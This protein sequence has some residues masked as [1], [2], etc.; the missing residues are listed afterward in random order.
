MTVANDNGPPITITQDY[1]HQ[2]EFLFGDLLAPECQ[3]VLDQN[4]F[5][6]LKAY[7]V[8][9]RE[10]GDVNFQLERCVDYRDFTDSAGYTTSWDNDG[11]VWQDEFVDLMMVS[12]TQNLGFRGGSIFREGV[13]IDLADIDAEIAR[14]QAESVERTRR[15]AIASIRPANGDEQT[16]LSRG[17]REPGQP[18]GE[19]T[20]LKRDWI[21]TASRS[22]A[23]AQWIADQLNLPLGVVEQVIG[24]NGT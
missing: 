2:A 18:Y 15:R 5:E 16:F 6:V 12:L 3:I 1:T 13:L 4:Q 17:P 9:I 21:V 11:E 19:L 23:P 10:V 20:D 14:L 7:L 22:E 24:E 8:H